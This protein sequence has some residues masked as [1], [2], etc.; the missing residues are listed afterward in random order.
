MRGLGSAKSGTEHF[1][2]QRLTAVAQIPLTLAFVVIVLRTVGKDHASVV[3]TVVAPP[4]RA[5]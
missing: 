3:A 1:W 5:S 4:C 2:R